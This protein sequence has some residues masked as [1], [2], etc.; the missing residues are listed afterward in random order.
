VLGQTISHYRVLEKLGE[1]GMG[2]VYKAEDT[3]LHRFVALKFLPEELAKSSQALERFEREA[4]A[5]SAL[6]HP[7]ICTIHDIDE[8]DGQPIIA[9]EFLEGQT[10]DHIIEGKPLRLD[11]LL[12]YAI[13]IADGLDAAHSKGIIH[14]DIKPAN[15]FVTTRGQA[16]ILD[17]GLAKLQ[18][19]GKQLE[20]AR[21]DPPTATI[22]TDHLTSPG[23]LVGTVAYMS[24]E[25]AR[26]EELDARTD[27]FSFGATLYEM[28]TGQRPFTGTTTALIFDAILNRM[29]APPVRINPDTPPMLEQIIHR[30]L[31]KD[32][33]ARYQEASAM[34]ADLQT[35]KRRTEGA[36]S[37]VAGAAQGVMPAR[38]RL[39]I[40]AALVVTVLLLG[41]AGVVLLRNSQ[42]QRARDRMLPEIQRLANEVKY[43][44]AYDL[45]LKARHE[46]GSDPE[47]ARLWA[48]IS[49]PVNIE[50]DPEG[51]EVFRKDYNGSEDHWRLIGVTPLKQVNVPR[52]YFRFKFLKPGYEI[53]YELAPANAVDQHYRLSLRTTVPP[54]MAFVPIA[55]FLGH[56]IVGL[57]GLD[58]TGID[59]FLIDRHEVTNREYKKFVDAGGYADA[60]YWKYKFVRDGRTV[61]FG[62]AMDGFRDATGRPGP[63][64]WEAGTYHDGLDDFPVGGIS[65][66]EAAAYADYAGKALPT[67]YHWFRAADPR[68]SPY[69][70][71]FSNFGG[72][73]PNAVDQ[74]RSIGPFGTVGMS[75]NVK[76]WCLNETGD[77]KNYI[78]GGGW[79]EPPYMFYNADA[80]RPMDRAP[81]FGVR[82][83]RYLAPLPAVLT[84]SRS[85]IIR[86]QASLKPVSDDVFQTY[87]ALYEYDRLEL[88]AT[89]EA[90]DDSSSHWKREK[91]TFEPTYVGPRLI[92]YLFLPKSTPPPWQVVVLG[93]GSLGRMLRSSI[94]GAE[95]RV[96]DFIPR[97]GRALVV[98][99]YWGQYERRELPVTTRLQQREEV[100]REIQDFRRTLDYLEGRTDLDHVQL[101]YYGTS[102]AAA[103]APLALA[104]DNRLKAAVLLDGG[105]YLEGSPPEVDAVNFAPRVRV[106]VLMLNGRFDYVFP[107]ETSQEILFRLL[108]TSVPEKRHVMFATAH[109]VAFFRNDVVRETLAWLDKY[110]GPVR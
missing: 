9:M 80:R 96:A 69:V 55:P 29:P 37:A 58:L 5:A 22:D 93:P 8:C 21:S 110:L 28:A 38:T 107:A 100:K 51:A 89:V 104:L 62:N 18:V 12:D 61:E 49:R 101:A 84:A 35:L 63:A 76:E 95:L 24:P 83:V 67:I 85:R 106:P 31:E 102:R 108:G 56:A 99:V 43:S 30:A 88:K 72:S 97:S 91:I 32:R 60:R 86:N 36:G 20:T 6:N 27:L 82:C 65:W 105:I 74:G 26:G 64:T 39:R 71:P 25:Q 34:R 68:T 16:K 59:A 75:G 4:H 40:L 81:T 77:G 15:I 92:V 42:V 1:G 94:D 47:L 57:G 14:R 78:L 44:D 7:N 70:L 48:D 45:A 90:V 109:D 79:N 41:L 10:L 19:A 17:F 46:L 13:Q 50:T 33:E 103:L 53:S 11:R 66:Y 52:G 23:T 2:I 98:P 73:G 54:E 3:K 87:R